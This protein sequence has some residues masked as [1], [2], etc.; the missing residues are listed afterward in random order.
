MKVDAELL[1]NSLNR[2]GGD[3]FKQFIASAPFDGASF[4]YDTA[5]AFAAL[6]GY[7]LELSKLHEAREQLAP[8]L[9]FFGI[10]NNTNRDIAQMES[11]SDKL[12]V[13]WSMKAE[14]DGAWESMSS[15]PFY[16][17][18]VPKLQAFGD[19]L[20]D[21]LLEVKEGKSWP[22]WRK[23]Y[24]E[25][26]QFRQTLPLV[27]NLLDPAIRDR[28]WER[29]KMEVAEKF[30]QHSD[31]FNLRAVFQYELLRRSGSLGYPGRAAQ[32]FFV[33]GSPLNL[34]TDLV[35]RLAE[36]A[37]K[38]LK[39]EMALNEI[40]ATWNSF[41]LKISPYKNN[42]L[43][44]EID[45]D[46]LTTLEEHLMSLSTIKS[47]QFHLPFKDFVSRWET[48]L[49]IVSEMLELLQQ[50]IK[51]LELVPPGRRGSRWW[52][53]D[54]F[55]SSE[56]ERLRFVPRPVAIEGGVEQWLNKERLIQS[57]CESEH[58]FA[59]T[60]QLRLELRE[61]MLEAGM[62]GPLFASQLSYSGI[63][64]CQCLQTET[65]TPYG[66]EYQ[67]VYSRLVITPLTDQC[68]M[69][70]TFA[71]HSKLGGSCQGP[72]GTGKTETVKDLGKTLARFVI[73]FN[74]SDAL[75]YLSLG[76][77]FSGLAQSGAWCC[78]DEFNRIGLE[79]LSV[80]AQQISTI[81]NALREV[82]PED[83]TQK[84][85]FF[86]GQRV[87]LD[88][89]CGIFT[90]MNPGYKGRAE[91]PE[92]LKSLFRPIAMMTPD[93]ALIC[94]ILLMAEGF[95]SARGLSKKA[96]TLFQLMAQQLSKQDHY[97]FGLRPIRS[98]LQRAGEIK[99]QSCENL[100]EQS[101]IIQAITDIVLPKSVSEDVEV[102]F[103]LIR[104]IFPEA[105]IVARE[106]ETLREGLEGVAERR[107]L[108]KV[109]YQILKAQQ[110]FQ[111]MQTR[112]GNM[113][114][115][116]TL[117][118]K[119]TVLSVLEQAIT[120]L[121]FQGM[122]YNS[123]KAHVLNPK[124]LD[125]AELYGGFS[126]TTREWT[127]G[128]F[129]ALLRTCCNDVQQ[130]HRCSRWV[131]LDGPVDTT[132]VESMNSLLDDNKTLTLTNGERIELHSQV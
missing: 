77:I 127:D 75:D 52:E 132:W 44:M 51:S 121:S 35:A 55:V 66:Y 14:W 32:D 16:S 42:M 80:V 118:G 107:G 74:C 53:A 125:A 101:I 22:I 100:T 4:N 95:D 67:G 12:S 43:R 50:G 130:Q 57:R 131:V 87:R 116:S 20:A 29:I 47:D 3:L 109:D 27:S 30:D 8:T 104:D 37:R 45:E 92:N 93:A 10:E 19:S 98:A 21:R 61:D 111:C 36:E 15:E 26:E 65:M 129:S 85:F 6:Q 91:L 106:S 105:D 58:H 56:G 49:T 97:D 13:V 64:V 96:V 84:K 33:C 102:L 46:F 76:R 99:R 24:S 120:H 40:V 78:F 123:V 117:S 39:I 48:T 69:A 25:I 73:V 59:W 126:T 81:Q 28:H 79:V 89:R 5:T 88:T 83:P 11:D 112:H 31:T 124:S 68:F 1:I 86:E 41:Q 114:V 119:S 23:V 62:G 70:L 115:G 72:A 122:D 71:V 9:D 90:T 7:K 113:L 2:R 63:L 18:A 128:I 110:L 94:E 38:E 108:T 17:L 34:P 60:S 103:A 82:N 54:G